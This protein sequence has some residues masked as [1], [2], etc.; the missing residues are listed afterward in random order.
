MKRGFTLIELLVVISIIAILTSLLLPALAKA[1]AAGQNI[2]CQGNLK[3]LSIAMINYAN[4]YAEWCAYN[5]GVTTSTCNYLY[6]P[7]SNEAIYQTSLCPYLSY[8]RF[9]DAID[10]ILPPAPVSI[11]PNGRMDGNGPRRSNGNPNF[12]YS[13]NI[14]LCTGTISGMNRGGRITQVKKPSR[15]VFCADS[16]VAAVNLDSNDDFPSRHQGAKDNLSF[17]DGHVEAWTYPQK[18]ATLNGW[19][20]GGYDGFWHDATW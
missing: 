2:V 6:G 20:P 5:D 11:C 7:I 10:H 1:R 12:S 3:Q 9:T 4:D 8:P 13:F 18:L 14:Y 19:T 16:I 17:V 15:R